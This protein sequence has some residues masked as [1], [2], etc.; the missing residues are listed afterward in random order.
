M[1]YF[2]NAIIQK[3]RSL[4]TRGVLFAGIFV[5]FESDT[6]Y[7]K[8]GA[9]TIDTWPMSEEVIEL[10]DLECV[11][12]RRVKIAPD[13]K[14]FFLHEQEYYPAVDSYYTKLTLHKANKT[15]LWEHYSSE[16]QKIS[17]ELSRIFNDRVIIVM[18]NVYNL[19]PSMELIEN[20]RSEML[21]H[22]E[23]WR[24]IV[25]YAVSPNGR[26]MVLHVKDPYLDKVWD[27]IHWIDTKTKKEWTYRFPICV[28]CKKHAIDVSITDDGIADIVYKLEHRVFNKEGKLIDIYLGLGE[29]GK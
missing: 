23:R 18:N 25:K 8:K 19:F 21:I 20:G 1:K 3:Y 24:R 6:L 12:T 9:H 11:R 16:F 28:S 10:A 22:E 17:F 15:V 14:S 26:F 27:Y 5:V 29:T 13:N 4:L 2:R 7:F